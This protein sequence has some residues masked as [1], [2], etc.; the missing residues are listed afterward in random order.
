MSRDATARLFVAVD[1]PA[2]VGEEV[3]AWARRAV[4]ASTPA[5]G[6]GGRA[7]LLGAEALHVTLCFLGSR[8][9][10]EIEAIGEALHE[11]SMPVG[12][13]HRGAPMWLPPHHPRVLAV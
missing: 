3:V 10:G 8:P 6:A 7:R 11:G 1:P 5:T 4:G 12:E 13:L 2:S 9:V